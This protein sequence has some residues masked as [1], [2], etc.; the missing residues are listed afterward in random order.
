VRVLKTLAGGILAV[1]FLVGAAPQSW[2]DQPLPPKL[3][4]DEALAELADT[5]IYRAPGAA[6]YL[7]EDAVRAAL[8][9]DTKVLVMPYTGRVEEGG[10]Y[11]DGDQHQAEVYDPI[12]TWATENKVNIVAVEGIYV[13]MYGDRGGRIGPSDLAE[14]RQTTAYLD[15]TEPVVF[16]AMYLAGDEEPD[17]GIE[18]IPPVPPTEDQLEDVVE[19]LRENRVYNAPGRDDPIDP[20]VVELARKHGISLRVAAFPVAEPGEPIVEYAPALR[21]QFPDDVIM[22]TT[23]R[24]LDVVAA[25]QDKAT[26]ARDFAFGRFEGGSFRQGS[27]MND[28][29]GTV[30]ER[31]ESLLKETAYGRPQPA[32][33]PPTPEYDVRRTI[34]TFAPWVLLGSALVLAAAGLIAYRA[35]TATRAAAERRA[36]YLASGSALARIN[37]LGARLLETA[38]RGRTP[39]AAAAERHATART[40]YDQ[41]HTSEAMAE[42]AKVATEGAELL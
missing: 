42:V 26:S 39:N 37:E 1:G 20:L 30:L 32:P 5:D 31:L 3:N 41:A 25:Q 7:D 16:G 22:V 10:N 36:M 27:P 19:E 11:A 18:P 17:T 12:D 23:G 33:Q 29:I 8:P 2:A 4:V 21:D 14:L 28:R 24:W 6:A 38:E 34:G 15:V 9:P 13:S 35:R 40:L